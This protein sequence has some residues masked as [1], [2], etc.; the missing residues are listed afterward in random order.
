MKDKLYKLAKQLVVSTE[1]AEMKE[2]LE[3]YHDFLT[4]DIH[5]KAPKI[6]NRSRKTF[7][8]I[9][10]AWILLLLSIISSY[11]FSL[12]YHMRYNTKIYL[13]SLIGMIC[14]QTAFL[15][16]NQK[17]VLLSKYKPR[18]KYEQVLFG[19]MIFLP[20]VTVST[21]IKFGHINNMKEICLLLTTILIFIS[22]YRV[23]Y[24][25][26]IFILLLIS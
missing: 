22:L 7:I 20:A 2:V 18:K 12:S 8:M 9:S 17:V 16:F 26:F 25:I 3:D 4:H 23:I 21:A 19:V 11:T 15:L 5:C 10:M 24:N 13:I 6:E 1:Y 14:I